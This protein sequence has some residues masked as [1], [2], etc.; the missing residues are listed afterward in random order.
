M[1]AKPLLGFIDTHTHF[2]WPGLAPSRSL[3][4]AM[5]QARD[6]A[7][8][9]VMGVLPQTAKAQ[10]Q[11]CEQYQGVYFALGIHPLYGDYDDVEKQL[12]RLRLLIEQYQYHPLF[13]G[14]GEIGLDGFD[15]RV[16]ENTQLVLFREQ[17]RLAREFALPVFM[18]VRKAQDMVLKHCRAFA[19][20]QGIAHA[21]NGSLQQATHYIEEGFKLGFGGVVT[22]PRAKQIRRLVCDLPIESIVIE[23]DTPDMP[24]SWAKEN[25]S[26]YI[27]EI[28]NTIA[29]LRQV[30]ITDLQQ[31][32]YLNS[33]SFKRV[34]NKF[35]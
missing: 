35:P 18:H 11:L 25:R 1:I 19:I 4:W 14:I 20:K 10:V 12:Q 21:F 26:F 9:W 27:G 33:I 23:T 31:Q 22:F 30:E 16:S 32:L 17:L 29:A 8:Q 7:S 15:K 24:P 28:A 5:A 13:L 2:D 6:V 3:D 34:Q